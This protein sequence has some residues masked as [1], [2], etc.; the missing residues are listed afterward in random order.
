M[1]VSLIFHHNIKIFMKIIIFKD[2][3]E[4]KTAIAR[5]KNSIRYTEI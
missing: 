2:K 4:S 5:E 3:F 1:K